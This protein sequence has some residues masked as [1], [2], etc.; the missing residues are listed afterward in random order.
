[1]SHLHTHQTDN[2]SGKILTRRT[3]RE[4][5]ENRFSG[6]KVL[7]ETDI[8][9]LSLLIKQGQLPIDEERQTVS[10]LR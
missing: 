5:H 9:L 3:E 7:T 10:L 4:A 2:Y 8:L 1:M 6:F